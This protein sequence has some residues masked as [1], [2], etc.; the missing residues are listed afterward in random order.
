MKKIPTL[1]Q[2]DPD[3]RARVL[4]IV[5]EGCEWVL[6]GEGVAKRKYDGT[7]V[8]FD[9]HD[10]WARREVKPDKEPPAGFDEISTD[11]ITGKRMGYEPAEQTGFAR[12][13]AEAV[14]DDEPPPGWVAGTYELCGPKIN[15]NPEHFTSH[16]LIRHAHA[17][18]LTLP[19]LTFDGLG[20][21]LRSHPFEGI[22]WHHPDGRMVKL[23]RRDFPTEP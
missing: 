13:L 20:D 6:A 9:G 17:E 16:V 8:M 4:P 2:R 22:V 18:T 7:C 12:F 5:T 15:G 3:D 19:S 14:E 23:K 1:F 10:W 21:W 11:T